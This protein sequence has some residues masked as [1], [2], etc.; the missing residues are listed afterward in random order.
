MGFAL[1]KAPGR[2]PAELRAKDRMISAIEQS[3]GSTDTYPARLQAKLAL[4]D[5][6]SQKTAPSL[7]L[8]R[9]LASS[10]SDFKPN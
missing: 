2:P 1:M 7:V 4:L 9:S 6:L 3:S 10:A 5:G 8:S